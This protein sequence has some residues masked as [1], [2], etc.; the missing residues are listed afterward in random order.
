[1]ILCVAASPFIDKLFEVDA[2]EVGHI[3]RP[4]AFVQVPGGKGLNVARAAHA[5]GADVF[6]TGILAGHAGRFV[7]DALAAEGVR[8]RFTW[9]EGETRS[10][11]SVAD[12]S[13]RGLTE[14]YERGPDIGRDGW[15]GFE[16]LVGKLLPDAAWITISG[17]LPVGAPPDGYARLIEAAVAAGVQVALDA[18]DEALAL[19]VRA[20]P[21]VVKVNT[22]E[23]GTL[24]GRDVRSLDG[25]RGAALE[26]LR[27]IG[28]GGRT[29]V[30]TRGAEGAIVAT[31]TGVVIRARLYDR[32]RYPVGS[33][34]AFLAGLVTALHGGGSLREALCLALGASAANAEMPG[35]GR[36]APARARELSSLAEVDQIPA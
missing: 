12:A 3:H 24:F 10:S 11:L 26:I 6:A 17:N 7:E 31:G 20:G 19:G 5:L 33:G 32:G 1:V 22:E 18:R 25:A 27:R 2:V 15:S 9:A 35:A 30:V 29:A 21:H 16:A 13:G 4:R 28:A 34:D 8:A 23:A 14:F 36:L